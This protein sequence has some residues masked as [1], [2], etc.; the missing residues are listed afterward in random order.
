MH[1][2]IIA[3]DDPIMLG[4]VEKLMLKEGHHVLKTT[5]A[6]GV[7]DLLPK[8]IPDL[9]LIDINLPDLN[10]LALCQELRHTPR[11][12]AI[13]IIFLTGS[14]PDPNDVADALNAGGDDFLYKPFA[15]RELAARVRAQLRR[16]QSRLES[17]LARLHLDPQTCQVE[18][19]GQTKAELTRVEFNLLAH[20]CHKPN[21]WQT[22][23]ELLAQVWR[24]P[25]DIGDAALVRNH[26][27]NIRRKIELK[28]DHPT[29]IL[30]RHRRGYLVAAQVH[31]SEE[32]AS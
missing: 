12:E 8:T 6:Q 9:F 13:P 5:S 19:N 25:G 17:S 22:T 24:Y 16:A 21:E 31:I 30:S 28:P 11:Y 1:T 3:D 14:T 18:I 2:I 26:I 15:A 7:H 10:G 27:R 20:M 29:I 23:R 4:M 32:T